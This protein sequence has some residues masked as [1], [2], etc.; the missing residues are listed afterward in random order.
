MF[1]Y[2][3]ISNCAGKIQDIEG[4][5]RSRVRA[6]PA[7]TNTRYKDVENKLLRQSAEN[8]MVG[9]GVIY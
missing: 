6:V 1:L 5:K 8:P 7:D 3:R 4:R 2:L 9:E